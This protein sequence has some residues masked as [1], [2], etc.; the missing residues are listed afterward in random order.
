MKDRITYIFIFLSY[1]L[2]NLVIVNFNLKEYLLCYGRSQEMV[3]TK[4]VRLSKP[5]QRGMNSDVIIFAVF[6]GAATK[7][8]PR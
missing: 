5:T 7:I 1:T 2:R 6:E 3:K 4:M 8:D